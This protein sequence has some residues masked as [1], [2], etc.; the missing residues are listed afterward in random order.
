MLR[1]CCRWEKKVS[2]KQTQRTFFFFN[3]KGVFFNSEGHLAND[4]LYSA[5]P[6]RGGRS[7]FSFTEKRK[8]LSTLMS[9]CR[10]EGVLNLYP[11]SSSALWSPNETCPGSSTELPFHTLKSYPVNH[12]GTI[13]MWVLAKSCLI[14][15]NSEVSKEATSLRLQSWDSFRW[16]LD[17]HRMVTFVSWKQL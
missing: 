9:A 7:R 6:S 16:Q 12:C 1:T 2:E 17:C 13:P 15:R 4:R 8:L 14:L 10:A 11:V 5:L 3:N